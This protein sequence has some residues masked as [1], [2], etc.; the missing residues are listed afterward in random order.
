MYNY[1]T[2]QSSRWKKKKIYVDPIQ[3]M[4][5]VYSAWQ[6]KGGGSSHE[7]EIQRTSGNLGMEGWHPLS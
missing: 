3:Y 1:T 2:T 7:G 6:N 4:S 5:M